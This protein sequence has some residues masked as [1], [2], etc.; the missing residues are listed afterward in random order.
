MSSLNISNFI[1]GNAAD[2]LPTPMCGGV[3]L[4]RHPAYD[5]HPTP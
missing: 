5:R 4:R 2:V 1:W 3:V